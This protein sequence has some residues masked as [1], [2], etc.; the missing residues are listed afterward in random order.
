[1]ITDQIAAEAAK[2]ILRNLDRATYK[3][4]WLTGVIQSAIEKAERVGY[5]MGL[6]AAKGGTCHLCD[7]PFTELVEHYKSA[8]P[9]S[10]DERGSYGA[11][12][13]R[14]TTMK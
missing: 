11:S 4:D 1:M 7:L 5:N 3:Q 14:N 12:V 13:S 2:T 9:R 6:R 10:T 8:H